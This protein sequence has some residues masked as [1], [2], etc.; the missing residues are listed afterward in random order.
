MNPYFI[1]ILLAILNIP[2]Y[3]FLVKIFFGDYSGLANAIRFL[4][5]PQIF[6]AFKG[7]FWDDWW[8]EI[9]LFFAILIIFFILTF[10]YTL[11]THFLK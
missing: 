1:W 6:S 7:E 3:H 11:I 5:T 10:E 4:L 2:L 9:K 8:E